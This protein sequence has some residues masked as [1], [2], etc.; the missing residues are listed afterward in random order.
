MDFAN[1]KEWK[2]P[3]NGSLV[4][5]I[6]VKDNNN[7]RVIWEKPNPGPDYSEPFW[8]ENTLS[9]PKNVTVT[10]ENSSR[11]F[12]SFYYSTNKS[13]WTYINRTS[14]SN[15]S[16]T[17]SIPANTKYY[18]KTNANGRLSY[19]DNSE[20]P[21]AVTDIIGD[22]SGHFNIGG[23]IMSLLFG[24]SFTEERTL[25]YQ[26]A[27]AAL[28]CDWTS[29]YDA[30]KLL[31]PA[32]TLSDKCYTQ[33]FFGCTNLVNPPETLPAMTLSKF[34]YDYMFANCSSL[35]TTPPLPAT[36]LANYCYRSMFN[37]CSSLTTAPDLLFE[38]QLNQ[39]GIPS[40]PLGVYDWMFGGCTSLNYVKCLYSV[41]SFTPT[42][43]STQYVYFNT[44]LGMVA[45][46]GTFVK[47]AGI[48]WWRGDS[49][50]PSD[51][52]II[53]Q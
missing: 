11:I 21:S 19:G 52:T 9:S 12:A 49:G 35:I 13:D 48:N 30:S 50:I 40:A 5:V 22:S 51:W 7:T 1:I 47:K 41:E 16:F 45:N 46:N 32:T 37:G 31:L 10:A 24:S 44:W 20:W 4:D 28:F 34:C 15:L 14:S 23:N 2:I 27:A 33:M 25:T 36:T 26:C 3:Y 29:L 39:Q 38:Y 6:S 17:F 8:I 42:G 53:E 43:Q 18:I